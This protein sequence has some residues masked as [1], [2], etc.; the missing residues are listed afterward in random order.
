MHL[1][2]NRRNMIGDGCAEPANGGL[3]ALG[4]DLVAEMNRL[5]IIVDIPH[6]G[7][8]T[9]LDAAE[10]SCK[11]VMASHTG[12]RA[13]HDHMRCKTD[14]ELRAIADTGGLIGVYV[15]P[16]MLGPDASLNTMLDHLDYIAGLVGVEH[17]AIGT[18]TSYAAEWPAGVSG[19]GTSR[20]S[21]SWWGGWNSVNHP[22]SGVSN[23]AIA[24]SLAWSNWPLFTV[25]LAMRGYSDSDIGKI[26]SGNFLRVLKAN[27]PEQEVKGV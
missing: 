3:S 10:V 27:E 14:A 24:G 8:R 6:S 11:P 5:G 4:R 19:Y 7:V 9:T 26:L 16:S 23:E 15:L 20:F 13:L 22:L 21:S 25:G 18:D 2:Y 17:V 1:T 12:A